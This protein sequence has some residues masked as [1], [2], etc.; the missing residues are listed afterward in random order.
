MSPRHF[1]ESLFF[2]LE[3][4]IT[5]VF[6][7]FCLLRERFGRRVRIP[8]LMYHQVSRLQDGTG[9]LTDCVS[10]ERFEDQMRALSEAGYRVVSLAHLVNGGDRFEICPPRR[11]LVV[12]TFDDGLR[13]QF[14]NAY[15]ILRRYG[16]S[17]TFFLVAGH[18]GTEGM[19]RLPISWDEA[20][21]LADNG[22]EIGSHSFS[23]RSLGCMEVREAAAEIR[24]SREML[25]KRLG[26]QVVFFAYPFGS[27]SYGDFDRGIQ[28]ILRRSG[29]HGACTT[30][31]GRNSRG[32]DPFELRRIPVEEGDGP[33]RLR[34]KLIGAYDWVGWI[35]TFYQRL[36]PREERVETAWLPEAREGSKSFFSSQ[37]E[38]EGEAPSSFAGGGG[39]ASPCKQP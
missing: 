28:E 15:P 37:S 10:P 23:H 35:K 21:A 27:P 9:S 6:Y 3:R 19:G 30:V 33:F 2:L 1:F 29:Y 14:V 5:A 17:A 16:F 4:V 7:P 18:V 25:E 31:V 13:D 26:V 12:L 22:M 11:Q 36:V 8:I 20:R 39:D 24:R 32:A 38:R 34:C